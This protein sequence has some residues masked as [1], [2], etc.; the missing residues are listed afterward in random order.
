MERKH[1][2]EFYIVVSSILLQLFFLKTEPT[3]LN[4]NHRLD[5]VRERKGTCSEYKTINFKGEFELEREVFLGRVFPPFRKCHLNDHTIGFRLQTRLDPNE[6]EQSK[7][8]SDNRH[9]IMEH[10]HSNEFY[11]V[12]SWSLLHLF[13]LNTEPNWFNSNHRLDYVGER[14]GTCSEYKTINFKGEFELERE[15]FLGCVCS[16]FRERHLNDHTIGFRL[17]TQELELHT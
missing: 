2:I 8:Q 9:D 14:N 3:W 11:F 16:P 1:F 6:Q 5:Y 4:S 7:F 15:V 17:Q 12:V 10:K 13:F